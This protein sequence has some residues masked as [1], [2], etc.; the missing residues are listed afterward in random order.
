VGKAGI[1]KGYIVITRVKEQD[2]NIGRALSPTPAEDYVRCKVA[3]SKVDSLASGEV[4][5]ET[6]IS[7]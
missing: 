4:H 6:L 1:W 7:E 3:V 5:L 2:V